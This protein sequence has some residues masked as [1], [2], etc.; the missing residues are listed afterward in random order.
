MSKEK[1]S[2]P[3]FTL[4]TSVEN[5]YPRMR[6]KRALGYRAPCGEI[7][8]EVAVR[9]GVVEEILDI[10]CKKPV[11]FIVVRCEYDDIP[12]LVGL[13]VSATANFAFR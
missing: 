4:N 6:Q 5:M 3:F 9:G 7:D 11:F 8:D 2:S 13:F 12:V 1:G 10:D